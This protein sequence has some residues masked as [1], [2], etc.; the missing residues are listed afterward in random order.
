MIPVNVVYASLTSVAAT[1][2]YVGDQR[3]DSGL[4]WWLAYRF[5][6]VIP[7]GQILQLD[8]GRFEQHANLNVRLSDARTRRVMPDLPEH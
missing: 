8:G 1:K 7:S 3:S 2:T 6:H 4:S 5:A